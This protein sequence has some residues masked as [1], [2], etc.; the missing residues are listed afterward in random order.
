MKVHL[1]LSGSN[2]EPV[3]VRAV[4]ADGEQIGTVR[5]HKI[6]KSWFALGMHGEQHGFYTT[7]WTAAKQLALAQGMDPQ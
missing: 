3:G 6:S 4:Y 5:Q 1:T 2:G 7:D